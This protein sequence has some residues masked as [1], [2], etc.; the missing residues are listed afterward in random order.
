LIRAPQRNQVC[1]ARPRRAVES[2]PVLLG[3]HDVLGGH[4]GQPFAGTVPDDDAALIIQHKRGYHQI[5]HELDGKTAVAVGL[6][7][8]H[9]SAS[10]VPW[11]GTVPLVGLPAL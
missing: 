5:L 4:A 2:P 1:Q 7:A 6:V 3:T 8:L 11:A 10:V 9:R